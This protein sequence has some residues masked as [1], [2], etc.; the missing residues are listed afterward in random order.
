MADLIIN[1]SED[2]LIQSLDFRLPSTSK[3]VTDRRLVRFYPSGASDFSPNGVR[4]ARVLLSGDGGWVDP[5]SLRVSFKI[6]NTGANN[7]YLAA[8]PHALWDRVRIFCAGTLVE[9]L[10]PHYGRLHEIFMNKLAPSNFN[11]NQAVLNNVMTEVGP[12]A[13]QSTPIAPGASATV[14]MPIACGFLK[15]HKYLPVRFAPVQIELSLADAEAAVVLHRGQHA[16]GADAVAGSRDYVIRQLTVH[17]AQARLDSALES[18]FAQVLLSNRALTVPVKTVATQVQTIP[19]GPNF[20]VSLVRALSRMNAVFLSFVWQEGAVGGDDENLHYHP[21][22]VFG[23]P[24]AIEGNPPD[25]THE[26]RTLE[27]QLAIG[28]KLF[29]ETPASSMGELFDNLTQAIDTY[30]QTLR[31]VSISPSRYR[32]NTFIAGFN[33]CRVPGHFASGV[34]TR[35]GD[36]LTIK[37]KNLKANMRNLRI[38]VH[39]LYEGI[40]EIRESGCSFYD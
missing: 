21:T 22:A 38:F 20:Q 30:D 23:N 40:L 7:L 31:T 15:T 25:A 39:V 8:G 24:S 37:A 14:M 17:C 13:V 1:S 29:P 26:E 33:M 34:N 5:S 10:G 11:Q 12:D 4:T 6:Q 19:D 28:S 3:Y 9:D 32:H 2:E 35:T 18:N 16:G 36:L 27:L